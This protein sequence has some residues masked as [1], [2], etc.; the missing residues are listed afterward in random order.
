MQMPPPTSVEGFTPEILAFVAKFALVKPMVNAA[1]EHP[2]I[3]LKSL[4]EAC[5][6]TSRYAE[7][8]AYS[9]PKMLNEV[10]L[11]KLK[12]SPVGVWRYVANP[13]L[14][15]DLRGIG[16][17]QL[18]AEF[19]EGSPALAST[20]Y[21]I[22]HAN[23]TNPQ[24]EQAALGIVEASLKDKRCRGFVSA[25]ALNQTLSSEGV[26]SLFEMLKYGDVYR[27]EAD[28][29]EL[30][31]GHPSGGLSTATITVKD[32]DGTHFLVAPDATDITWQETYNQAFVSGSDGVTSRTLASLLGTQNLGDP[33]FRTLALEVMDKC[34]GPPV[35]EIIRGERPGTERLLKLMGDGHTHFPRE[36]VREYVQ[37]PDASPTMVAELFSSRLKD[38]SVACLSPLLSEEKR[39]AAFERDG[40]SPQMA[41]KALRA[42]T[43]TDKAAR[44]LSESEEVEKV[45]VAAVFP[46][47]SGFRLERIMK[48]HPQTTLADLAFLHPNG[49]FSGNCLPSDAYMEVSDQMARQA[50]TS[51]LWP[52]RDVGG[53]ARANEVL[54]MAPEVQQR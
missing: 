51:N 29:A 4:E 34:F 7:A 38:D 47:T 35:A 46:H 17:E 33:H 23:L 19:T 53:A 6:G 22:E 30:I 1:I 12:E 8:A 40:Y 13:N 15:D 41:W 48:K 9:H 21:L 49:G 42:G 32:E 25:M 31:L 3:P 5:R 36:A 27:P 14:P 10:T 54:S 44:K 45:M 50:H 39:D 11:S 28:E 2:D 52:A 20:S 24:M 37:T 18:K 16:M 26:A 43:L